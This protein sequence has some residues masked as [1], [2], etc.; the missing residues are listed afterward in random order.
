MTQL[1]WLKCWLNFLNTHAHTL[2]TWSLKHLKISKLRRFLQRLSFFFSDKGQSPNQ[3]H[4]TFGQD[5]LVLCQ[6]SYNRIICLLHLN[7]KN[8][9]QK[10]SFKVEYMKRF[11]AKF[12]T[13]K[14]IMQLYFLYP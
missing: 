8:S 14:P 5:F 3:K 7:L 9:P 11:M 1:L 10:H 4:L 12:I 13:K 6:S 2:N